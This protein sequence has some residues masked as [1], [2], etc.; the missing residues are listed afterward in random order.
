MKQETAF[1]QVMQQ[2]GQGPPSSNFSQAPG[3]GQAHQT[4]TQAG[5]TRP[6][7][8]PGSVFRPVQP[9]PR[10]MGNLV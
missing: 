10:P 8:P 3:A 5:A 7:R 2:S 9:R 6:A 4:A 1:F